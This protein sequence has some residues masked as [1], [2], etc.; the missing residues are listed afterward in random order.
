MSRMVGT[1][2]F[3]RAQREVGSVGLG[4]NMV[5]CPFSHKDWLVITPF[6][7]SQKYN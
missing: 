6:L 1:P 4:M 7:N 2:C 5:E 3:G